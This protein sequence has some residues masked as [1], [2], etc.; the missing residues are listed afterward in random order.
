MFS[1]IMEKKYS[2]ILGHIYSCDQYVW[3]CVLEYVHI[4]TCTCICMHVVVLHILCS[5]S[6]CVCECV[7]VWPHPLATTFHSWRLLLRSLLVY[8]LTVIYVLKLDYGLY[9]LTRLWSFTKY[10]LHRTNVETIFY[11]PNGR[12]KN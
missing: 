1:G 8:S 3:V 9:G 12:V 4:L 10:F 7:H 5:F 6:L 2:N 11:K